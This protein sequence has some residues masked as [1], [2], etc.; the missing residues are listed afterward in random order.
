MMLT[1]VE[2][3]QLLYKNNIESLDGLEMTPNLLT[4]NVAYNLITS[5]QGALSRLVLRQHI[6]SSY[7]SNRFT[8]KID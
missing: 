7:N 6:L 3:L 5:L 2:H 8:T 1:I 4:L